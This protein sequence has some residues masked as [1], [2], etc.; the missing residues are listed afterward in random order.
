MAGQME[1]DSTL[2]DVPTTWNELVFHFLFNTKRGSRIE[3]HLLGEEDEESC[4]RCLAAILFANEELE[5]EKGAVLHAQYVLAQIW[6]SLSDLPDQHPYWGC[7]KAVV[8]LDLLVEMNK[9]STTTALRHP[10]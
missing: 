8:V 2:L 9:S 6:N 7:L 10:Q 4:W 3:C 5:M 1:K